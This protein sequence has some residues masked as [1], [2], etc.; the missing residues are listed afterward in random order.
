MDF[1]FAVQK[2]AKFSENPG[3]VH[4]EVLVNLLRYIRDNNI[5]SLK[6]YD[7]INDALVSN[8]LIQA[9]IKNENQLMV[10]PDYSWQDLPDNDIG[11][12]A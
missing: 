4:F 7:N 12:G 5:L 3:K 10:F 1:C 2:L 11:T 6:Y 8:L 9:S